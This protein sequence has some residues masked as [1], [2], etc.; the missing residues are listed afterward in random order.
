M[1][2][3]WI[4]SLIR[5]ARR[6]FYPFPKPV[7]SASL[8]MVL[9]LLFSR[10]IWKISFG[11]HYNIDNVF[12]TMPLPYALWG[13][14]VRRAAKLKDANDYEWCYRVEGQRDV[15]SLDTDLST[16]CPLTQTIHY[17]YF[18]SFIHFVFQCTFSMVSL[19]ILQTFLHFHISHL[20]DFRSAL[21]YEL[22]W[23]P[24]K[25]FSTNRFLKIQR[26]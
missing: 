26:C 22:W 2:F 10:K 9:K 4:Q 23:A 5:G 19:S 1:K 13:E 18:L 15:S 8:F 16:I 12:S 7:L 25:I 6:W 14:R 24:R 11:N 21:I 17:Y 20:S 3:F